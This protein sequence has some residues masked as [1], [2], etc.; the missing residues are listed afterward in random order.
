MPKNEKNYEN[1]TKAQPHEMLHSVA[2]QWAK[3]RGDQDVIDML[4]KAGAME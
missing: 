3:K 4:V 2:L 1:T